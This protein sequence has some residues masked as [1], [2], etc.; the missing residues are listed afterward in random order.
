MVFSNYVD[1]QKTELKIHLSKSFTGPV[2]FT[3][4]DSCYNNDGKHFAGNNFYP[5]SYTAN[6]SAT[7]SIVSIPLMFDGKSESDLETIVVTHTT[8]DSMYTA[9]AIAIIGL[10]VNGAAYNNLTFPKLDSGRLG[11]T[12]I[13]SADKNKQHEKRYYDLTLDSTSHQ[14]RAGA[15]T[16]TFCYNS[17]VT[18]NQNE[19]LGPTLSMNIY[20]SIFINVKNNLKDTTT[21][22]WHGFHIPAEWDGGPHEPIAPGTSWSPFFTLTGWDNAALYWYHPHLHKSTFYQVMMGAAGMIIMRG[23]N[24]ENI[25]LPREYGVD[26]IPMVLTSRRLLKNN[27]LATNIDK[28]QFGDYLLTNG[29]M[30]AQ[31]TLPKQ[32]VRIRILNAEVERGYNIGFSDDRSFAIIGTD[33][34]LM[35]KPDTVKRLY[36]LPGE[37]IE[38]IVDLS[39]DPLG[40]SLDLMAFNNG[41][42]QGFPGSNDDIV[43]PNGSSGPAFHSFL[44]STEF[45]L[46]HITVGDTSA[47]P[48]YS[49]PSTLANNSYWKESEVTD[50]ITDTINGPDN[51]TTNAHPLFYFD[52]TAYEYNRINHIIPINSIMKWTFINI[53]SQGF[54]HPIHIHDIAFNIVKRT[55]NGVSTGPFSYENGWKDVF[56]IRKGETVEVIA[57]FN[58]FTDPPDF[59]YM[60]HCHIL[61]HEDLGLMGQFIVVADSTKKRKFQALR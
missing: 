26:D 14:F 13:S 40:K 61:S 60:Y 53:D 11:G 16:P 4:S 9:T 34:G 36:M 12:F 32:L 20:D 58:D 51:P 5:T 19:F 47:T 59:P 48:V 10:G 55:Y 31:K 56:Y 25:K 28:D 22:H 29:V 21:T 41:L 54:G 17:A 23:G 52:Q 1:S 43:L 24:K 49:L 46:L 37:R 45:N 8:G 2:T 7:D 27:L 57:N 15:R 50:A 18:N 38:F 30:S 42:E 6:L 35:N 3:I 39:K 33:G 44:S